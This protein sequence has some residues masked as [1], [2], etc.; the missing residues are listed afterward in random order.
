M[1]IKNARRKVGVN[2]AWLANS[3]NMVERQSGAGLPDDD[4]QPEVVL[5]FMRDL[6]DQL[7]FFLLFLLLFFFLGTLAPFL[8]AL[9]RPITMACF[10]L[11][12]FFFALPLWSLPFFFLCIAFLTSLL[13][14]LPYFAMSRPFPNQVQAR[15]VSHGVQVAFHLR[16][17]GRRRADVWRA[18]AK[19]QRALL[20]GNCHCSSKKPASR[21]S[22][23]SGAEAVS[24]CLS[25]GL[26]TAQSPWRGKSR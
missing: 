17:K 26:I 15:D 8:R 9:D 23:A 6:N 1:A 14:F 20:L 4:Y 13:A 18:F 22:S 12:T 5:S 16:A 11:L 25:P 21:I 2:S 19:Y 24:G 3:V 7:F 10:L